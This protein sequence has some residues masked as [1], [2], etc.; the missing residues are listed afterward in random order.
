MGVSVLTPIFSLALLSLSWAYAVYTY[1][2]VESAA[3][4][5]ASAGVG[6][7]ASILWVFSNRPT[8]VKSRRL[9]LALLIAALSIAAVQL[10][11]VPFAVVRVISPHRASQIS[12]A[13][14]VLGSPESISLNSVPDAGR[15]AVLILAAYVLVYLLS[16]DLRRRFH[17]KPW[18]LALPVLV[19]AS[20]EAT[21]GVLQY[22]GGA[23]T[24]VGTYVNRNHF[25]GL[26]EMSLPFA[27]LYGFHL[28]E[29]DVTRLRC[30]A[31]PGLLACVFFGAAA[32][33]LVG[34]VHS[35]S[36]MGFV[37]CLSALLMIGALGLW[38]R[39]AEGASLLTLGLKIAGLGAALVLV[40][41]FLSSD[42]LIGRFASIRT[43]VEMSGDARK[44]LWKET[45]PLIADYPAAGCG[46]GAYESCF[47]PY[48]SVAPDRTADY[49]HNDYLQVMAELGLPAFACLLTVVMMAYWSALLGAGPGRS[50][51]FL[52]M[53]CVGSLT[54]I[55]LH[56]LVD[57]NMY[58]PANGMLAA[59][60]AGMARE[61]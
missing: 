43:A 54:A 52:A 2:G 35:H 45:I 58:I 38:G 50:S 60:V 3:G 61:A 19:M 5:W 8:L 17:Q 34:V 15:D 28:L 44:Q 13:G 22:Y 6:V 57:F 1:G 9:D 31:V 32:L 42:E 33:M 41:V 59:W 20:L 7:A 10:I 16:S 14:P 46:L 49:A 27:V 30:T 26:L 39:Y 40:F 36:R 25:A 56:S 29:R 51:R 11:R 55:L 4:R 21:L 53:A 48:K 47:M 37:A 18:T 23:D 12:T 24:A